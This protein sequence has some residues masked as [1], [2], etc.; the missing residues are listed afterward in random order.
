MHTM[1]AGSSILIPSK[2]KLPAPSL[3][4]SFFNGLAPDNLF[5]HL[6][7]GEIARREL[8]GLGLSVKYDAVPMDAGAAE[9]WEGVQNRYWH[10]PTYFIPTC[11]KE[12]QA[13]QQEGVAAGNAPAQE[14]QPGSSAG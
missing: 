5:F 7:Y 12:A 2:T 4:Y 13:E 10:L 6:V 9:I 11:I 8:N 1:I 3:R 14:E